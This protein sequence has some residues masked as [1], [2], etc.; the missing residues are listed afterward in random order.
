[1]ATTVAILGTGKMGAAMARRLHQQGFELRLWNRT[2]QRA[3]QL[4]VGEV[5]DTPAEA[6][7][8]AD[9]VISMLTDPPAVRQVYLGQ[10]GALEAKG[11]RVY[12]D[13]STVDPKT[14]EELARAAAQR[15]STFVEAPVLGSVPAVE[16]GKLYI[17][18][19]GEPAAF[20]RVRPVL[21]ALGDVR[22]V[23]PL[24]SAARLKL[25][26]NSMLAVISAAAGELYNAGLRAGLDRERVWEILIRLA[27][28]LDARRAGFMEGR[29]EPAMFALADML[30]DL[31]L[32]LGLYRDVGIETPLTETTAQLF[33][34]AAQEHAEQDLAA[35]ADLWRQRSA[36]ASSD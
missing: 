31:E 12:I 7:S 9:V 36:A 17:M 23:G 32:A 11:A 3:E 20:E 29:Y 33:Q 34:R 30:K 19:G 15:E 25:V 5:F 18:V 27:P 1:M 6:A 22:Y 35:I 10:H 28:Y 2:R 26:A 24:G 21:Q 4:G 8:T 16:A 13:S 14:H